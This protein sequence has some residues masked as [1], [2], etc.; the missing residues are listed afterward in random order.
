MILGRAEDGATLG[1]ALAD[2]AHLLLQ[3]QNGSGKSVMSYGL[4]GQAAHARDVIVAGCDITG[5]LLGR[6][7]EGTRHRAWQAAGTADLE[8]HAVILERLVGDMDRRLTDMPLG[9]DKLTPTPDRPLMFVVMEEWPGLLRAAGSLPKPPRGD[10]SI[11]DRIKSANL[12]L[13][14]EGRKAAFR[15]L[16]LAQRA[17]AEAVGGGY[18]RDQ[19]ALAISFR[20]PSESL[21]MAH[22]EDAREHGARHRFAEPGIALISA[23][24]RPLTRMRAPYVG[25]YPEYCR[26]VAGVEGRRA[27]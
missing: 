26:R 3:G 8:A 11:L 12:R 4:I 14:S 17:E 16:T 18:A 27:A 9:V 7:F 15:V 2:A 10:R 1:H 19:Y 5:L 23:P 24:G 21:V 6:P 20:V 13:L 25:E 22:G